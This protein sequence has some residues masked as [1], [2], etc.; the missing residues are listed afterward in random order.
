MSFYSEIIL[1]VGDACDEEA[2]DFEIHLPK[3]SGDTVPLT[4]MKGP[5]PSPLVGFA[6]V[7]YLDFAA[8]AKVLDEH[9]WP[10]N[11]RETSI[12]VYDDEDAYKPTAMSVDEAIEWFRKLAPR[13]T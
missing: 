7:K 1:I 8:A 11:T 13:A 3:S 9:P 4:P 2:A 12:L 5:G 6:S 10:R